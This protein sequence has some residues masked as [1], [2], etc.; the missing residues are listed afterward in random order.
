MG[1]EKYI[2][3]GPCGMPPPLKAELVLKARK[4]VPEKPVTPK[5]PPEFKIAPPSRPPGPAKMPPRA[6]Y[7]LVN[8]IVAAKLAGA[9]TSSKLI[10]IGEPQPP[11]ADRK[12]TRLNS[13]H[14]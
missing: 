3:S 11:E 6:A 1:C 9:A 8:R 2:V 10:T 7:W 14:L 5:L 13:S 12:S 4:L